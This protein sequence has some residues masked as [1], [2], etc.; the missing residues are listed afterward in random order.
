MNASTGIIPGSNNAKLVAAGIALF[1]GIIIVFALNAKYKFLP[2]SMNLFQKLGLVKSEDGSFWTDPN[3]MT[4][5]SLTQTQMP[6][7]FPSRFGYS[8]MFDIMIFNSRASMSAATGG[9]LPYRHIFHRGSNELGNAGTPA[10]CGGGGGSAATGS[11]AASSGLPKLMNP[12]FFA[13]PTTND[14]IVFIDTSAGRE[15][16]RITNHQLATP[17][18][19][20]I[21]VYEGFFEIYTGCKL[22][23]TQILKGIPVTVGSSGIYALAGSRALSAKIQNLRLWSTT[24]PV[25]QVITECSTP[26]QPFGSAPPCMATVATIQTAATSSI[27]GTAPA[28]A[29]ATTIASSLQC[30][31]TS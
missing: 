1:A 22:L 2:A 31:P 17:Y 23:T 10:G 8:M 18:R 19:I 29:T 12:G 9:V 7:N 4:T 24:L 27:M 28:Q 14:V 21:I 20:G 30:P 6:P 16:S 15:S 5:L 26:M 11:T 25:Q 13:D 3:S